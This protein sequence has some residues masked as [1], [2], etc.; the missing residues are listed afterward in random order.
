MCQVFSTRSQSLVLS[1]LSTLVLSR[2][3]RVRLFAT[4][5]SIAHQGPL[6]IGFPRQEYWNGISSSGRSSWP[7]D[8]TRLSSSSLSPFTNIVATTPSLTLCL[9]PPLSEP[10]VLPY[11][12]Q[13]INPYASHLIHMINKYHKNTCVHSKPLSDF[14]AKKGLKPPNP[15]SRTRS[16]SLL[17]QSWKRKEN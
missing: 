12:I 1:V 8:R 16:L 14:T 10:E 11:R 7:K 15:H 2:F 6:S 17:Q 13:I 4:P 3:S 5:C 9:I